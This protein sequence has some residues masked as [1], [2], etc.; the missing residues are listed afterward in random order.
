M[1]LDGTPV[2]K[3]GG[4]TRDV[5]R[6]SDADFQLWASKI[7]FSLEPRHL[8]STQLGMVRTNAEFFGLLSE[9][10]FLGKMTRA[11]SAATEGFTGSSAV[12]F[13]IFL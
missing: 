2:H 4:A 8:P 6:L 1:A 3:S 5:R 13:G 12:A 10:L 9:I 11:S 7:G